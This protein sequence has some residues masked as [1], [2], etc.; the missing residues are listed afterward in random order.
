MPA[1]AV[2]DGDIILDIE[3][4]ARWHQDSIAAG[5][6]P[7]WVVSF[8]LQEYPG[9]FVARAWSAAAHGSGAVVEAEYY[10]AVLLAPTIE[11]VRAL[12]P[13]GLIKISRSRDDPMYLVERWIS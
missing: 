8:G 4:A 9:V 5:R 11:A 12:L 3:S 1:T 2:N 6:I 10:N 7:L 13:S